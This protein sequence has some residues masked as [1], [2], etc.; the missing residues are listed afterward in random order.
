MDPAAM[1]LGVVR[2]S[3]GKFAAAE[4]QNAALF[5]TSG[6]IH[7]AHFSDVEASEYNISHMHQMHP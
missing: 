6:S 3:A 2:N 7:W 4:M 5:D 1:E